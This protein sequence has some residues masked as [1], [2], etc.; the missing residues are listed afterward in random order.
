MTAIGK[1]LVFF[2]LLFSLGVGALTVLNFNARTYW[3]DGYKK[4]ETQATIADASRLAYQKQ[5]K[6]L[7]DEKQALNDKL[8]ALVGK[9]AFKEPEKAGEKLAALLKDHQDQNR[10]LKAEIDRLNVA[11]TAER[12]KSTQQESVAKTSLLDV[13]R[14][15]ADAEKMRETLK[16]ETERNILLVKEKNELRDRAV[17]AEIQAKSFKEI[18]DRLEKQLQE[19]ARDMARLKANGGGGGSSTARGV[20]P[21]P[22]NVEGLI[23]RTDT[24]S[25]LVTITIGSDA[26]LSKGNTMEVFRLGASP[27]Y[28]GR[29]KIIEVTHN[30]AVGQAASKL[31]GQIQVGDHVASRI[32]AGN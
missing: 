19:M 14:R 15:Q 7:T 3:A 13:E 8:V 29:I 32:L 20:N 18:D 10:Q 26:G 5:N 1:I 17:I 16:A 22:D 11:L 27:K 4:L 21:P 12:K 23:Q 9:D 25:G 31:N 6:E 28:V 24:N 2:N 30:Q